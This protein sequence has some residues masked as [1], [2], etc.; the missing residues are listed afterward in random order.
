MPE[1]PEVE[2]IKRDLE[3]KIKNQTIDDIAVFDDR[4]I[5]DL[6]PRTFIRRIKKTS[7]K[8]ITRKGKALIIT[9]DP[10]GYL[11]VQLKMTGQLI[12]SQ[13][14]GSKDTK[15][16]FKLSNGHYLHYNDQ[17]TLG[18]LIYVRN[19]AEVGYLNGLGPEPL[20][21]SF[22]SAWLREALQ[23]RKGPIK[24]L[25]M[26]HQFVAGIGNIYASEILFKA[27]IHPLRSSNRLTDDEVELLHHSTVDILNEAIAHRGS[28]MRDY[29]DASGEK[30]QFNQRIKVY[31]RRNEAC[32]DCGTSIERIVQA[33]RSTF[34]CKTCQPME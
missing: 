23:R 22:N 31:G 30:G 12:Y 1:L 8:G 20:S 17:R 10:Q 29:R 5:K 21:K 3:K 16:T 7:I 34:Y 18:W 4:V 14:K 32:V 19:L 2:T 15:V 26:N 33:G 11:V 9:F 6:S 27:H 28:S 24:P 25:L 13:T